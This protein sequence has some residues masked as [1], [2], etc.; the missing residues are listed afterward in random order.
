[1]KYI[2]FF[3]QHVNLSSISPSIAVILQQMYVN[4]QIF[5]S[6]QFRFSDMMNS[7][8]ISQNH[9]CYGIKLETRK[10]S[11]PLPYHFYQ[12]PFPGDSVAKFIFNYF[13][14]ENSSGIY[15]QKNT[16]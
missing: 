14:V 2:T 15:T 4:F 16:K 11:H 5:L 13:L 12:I 10:G 8:R 1:M 7:L 6:F 9:V 3:I